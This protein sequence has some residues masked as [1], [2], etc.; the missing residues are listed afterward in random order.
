MAVEDLSALIYLDHNVDVQLAVD[1][2]RRGF[3][4][5]H[6]RD[7]GMSR[8]TDDEHLERAAAEG[9]VV[10]TYD[11]RD[12]DL[13][14]KAWAREKRQHAGIIVS[15]APPDLPYGAVLRRLLNLL[16]SRLADQLTWLDA[17]WEPECT[18]DR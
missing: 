17:A 6:A 9:R 16:D 11:R 13:L 7:V 1:L 3:D 18:Q 4:V 15:I 5:I 14:A 2:H 10:L 8:A 12:F